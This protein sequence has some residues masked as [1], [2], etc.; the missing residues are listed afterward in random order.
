LGKSLKTTILFQTTALYKI[1][2]KKEKKMNNYLQGL[3]QR[4][5]KVKIRH[6][7][8]YKGFNKLMTRGEYEM[9]VKDQ[10]TNLLVPSFAYRDLVESKKGLTE[11]E[12]TKPDGTVILERAECSQNENYDKRRGLKIALGRAMKS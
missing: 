5:Y 12:I 9:L 8:A 3:R 6:K 1:L 11:V 7:R 4:G 10:P 2:K